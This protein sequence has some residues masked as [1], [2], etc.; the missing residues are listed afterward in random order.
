MYCMANQEK[1]PTLIC[2]KIKTD[3]INHVAPFMCKKRFGIFGDYIPM[4]KCQDPDS[5]QYCEKL[6][7]NEIDRL[8]SKSLLRE[9]VNDPV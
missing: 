5:K 2:S 6:T 3:E 1:I 8:H 4:L 7:W 9:K